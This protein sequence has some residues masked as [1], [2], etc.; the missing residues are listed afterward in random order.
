MPVRITDENW[1]VWSSDMD[2][3]PKDKTLVWLRLPDGTVDLARWNGEWIAEFGN[4]DVG[5]VAWAIVTI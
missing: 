2:A 5:P 3:V 1:M 4:L